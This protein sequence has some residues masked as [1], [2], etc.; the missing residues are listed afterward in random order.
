MVTGCTGSPAAHPARR[1][2]DARTPTDPMNRPLTA[3]LIALA[4]ALEPPPAQAGS[5]TLEGITFSDEMGGVVLLDAYG[6]GRLDDPFVLIEEIADIGPA[7]VTVSGLTATFGNR[8]ESH[9]VTGFAL[10]KI[11]R[12]ATPRPW[13][14]FDLELQEVL[15][16]NSTYYDGLSFGQA[17]EMGR[18]FVSDRY[19]EVREIIEPFDGVSFSG[20]KVEPGESV[21]V[22]VVVTDSTPTA[23]FYLVQKHGGPMV[24]AAP[25][26]GEPLRLTRL[27]PLRR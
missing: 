6:S 5:F 20:A 22:S 19:V 3:A 23:R 10:T 16:H 17:T 25:P 14:G 26:G 2:R 18:P 24:D 8:I 21:T 13:A 1:K 12:N 11:V 9:H 15:G 27:G 4:C 7:V